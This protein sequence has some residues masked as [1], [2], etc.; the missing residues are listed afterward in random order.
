VKYGKIDIGSAVGWFEE[1]Y[2]SSSRAAMLAHTE[3]PWELFQLLK[4]APSQKRNK[5]PNEISDADDYNAVHLT[6]LGAS[7]CSDN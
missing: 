5:I 4:V 7:Q 2:R 6:S 3:R 1:R